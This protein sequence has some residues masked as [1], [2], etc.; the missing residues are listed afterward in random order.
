MIASALFRLKAALLALLAEKSN[1]FSQ[2]AGSG[3]EG[4]SGWADVLAARSTS[5]VDE[6]VVPSTS[7]SEWTIT[8]LL[9]LLQAVPWL[10]RDREVSM[11]E[12]AAKALAVRLVQQRCADADLS[13][14]SVDFG[15]V[16]ALTSLIN[17]K[18]TSGYITAGIAERAVL[19]AKPK[20][21]WQLIK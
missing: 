11:E 14:I 20:H 7:V 19:P 21:V 1:E 2:Y 18:S 3:D 10:L 16:V 12:L 9:G 8:Q 4:V 5:A 6:P 17:R 15:T 13:S